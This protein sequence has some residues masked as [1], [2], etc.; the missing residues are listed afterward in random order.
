MQTTDPRATLTAQLELATRSPTGKRAKPAAVLNLLVSDRLARF[1]FWRTVDLVLYLQAQGVTV[2]RAASDDHFSEQLARQLTAEDRARAAHPIHGNTWSERET[3]VF[4]LARI[5]GE[6]PAETE[7]A[8]AERAW[9]DRVPARF[10][11]PWTEAERE[12][13]LAS[14]EVTAEVRPVAAD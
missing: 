2:E 13:Y 6:R 9:N 4:L 8:Q 10:R 12:R 7:Q 5:L 3:I 14:T 1:T 11:R